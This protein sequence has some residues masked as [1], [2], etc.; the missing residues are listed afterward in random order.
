MTCHEASCELQ[1]LSA[2]ISDEAQ[3]TDKSDSKAD[4]R[5]SV[6]EIVGLFVKIFTSPPDLDQLPTSRRAKESFPLIFTPHHHVCLYHA[7]LLEDFPLNL[8]PIVAFW[9]LQ[10]LL[11]NS[12]SPVL[13]PSWTRIKFRLGAS[14]RYIP[15]L[16]LSEAS[17][18]SKSD[19]SAV[20]IWIQCL[21]QVNTLLGAILIS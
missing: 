5:Q 20:V 19:S 14:Q 8:L 1:G 17:A 12:S 13:F 7:L 21:T 4:E 10:Y 3:E 9:H 11:F 16:L 18:I 2:A 15:Y 6:E